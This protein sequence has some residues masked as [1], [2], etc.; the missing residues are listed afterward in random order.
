MRWTRRIVLLLAGVFIAWSLL[1]RKVEIYQ[2]KSGEGEANARRSGVTCTYF[3]FTPF[4]Y[5]FSLDAVAKT[6]EM[7]VP[8]STLWA[9]HY[10]NGIPWKEA[11]A[12]APFPARFQ[13]EWDDHARAIPSDHVVY[14]A[15]A[16]LD[17]DRKSL[18]P[19]TGEKERLELPH[20]LRGVPLDDPNVKQAYLNYARRAVKQFRPRYLNLGIEA[21]QMMSRDFRRWP[22]FERLYEHVRSAIKKDYPELQIGISFGLGDLRARH[23]AEA[24]KKLIASSD[25]VGISF[26][27]Y[28]S[29]FD[30]KFGAP[31]FRGETPWREPLAWLR[32]YT[33]KPLAICETGFTTQDIDIPQYSLKMQGSPEAQAAYTQALFKLARE[34]RYVLVVWFLAIDYD[35]LYAKL[36]AGSEAMKL[37]KNIGFLDGELRPKAA[38][39]FWKAGVEASR[40]DLPRQGPRGASPGDGRPQ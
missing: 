12:D 40:N 4:P 24:A 37:W 18:A 31:P 36:P 25:Y 16:P 8:H 9:L 23:E 26:Y 21:G 5:D 1:A 6:R 27:P 13:R 39:E 3:G 30:E 10:D 2:V 29:A 14:L 38:W 34:D 28:A 33:D 11:L 19:A 35:K 20:E 7:I 15:L 17:K 32:A 22:Q